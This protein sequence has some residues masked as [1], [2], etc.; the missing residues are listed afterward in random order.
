MDIMKNKKHLGNQL[1]PKRNQQRFRYKDNH[2]PH[3]ETESNILYSNG[4]STDFMIKELRRQKL[5]YEKETGYSF[6]RRE[7]GNRF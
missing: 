7:I 3:L 4:K 2:I 1:S 5:E 6:T